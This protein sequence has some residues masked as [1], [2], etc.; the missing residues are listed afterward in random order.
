MDRLDFPAAYEVPD[1]TD[2]CGPYSCQLVNHWRQEMGSIQ[3]IDVSRAHFVSVNETVLHQAAQCRADPTPGS[4]NAPSKLAPGPRLSRPG[5][6]DQE[7]D[8]Q[9]RRE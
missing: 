8:V 3:A 7:L 6:L 5:E 2:K 1:A 4:V 9:A